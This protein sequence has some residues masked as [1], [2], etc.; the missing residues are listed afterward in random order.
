M[1]IKQLLRIL[2]NENNC[3]DLELAHQPVC[4]RPHNYTRVKVSYL[5]ETLYTVIL[6]ASL[7]TRN[8]S[9]WLKICINESS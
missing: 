8:L 7:L 9:P 3:G 5:T 4:K 1:Y 2:K 6:P